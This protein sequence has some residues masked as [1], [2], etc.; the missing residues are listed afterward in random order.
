M[1]VF[2]A[3]LIRTVVPAIVGALA[4]W[5]LSFGLDVGP[6]AYAGLTAFLGLLFT[7]VYYAVVRLIEDR[8][9]QVGWLLG[10]AKSP[11]SYSKGPGVVLEQKPEGNPEVTIKVEGDADSTSTV[12]LNNDFDGDVKG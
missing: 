3:G 1:T 8:V 5:L 11:D 7:A 10:L 12:T 9:P 4:T 6:D 2:I